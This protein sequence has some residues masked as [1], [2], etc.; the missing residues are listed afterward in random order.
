MEQA[1]QN[2]TEKGN[3]IASYNYTLKDKEQNEYIVD[4]IIYEK[5]FVIKAKQSSD[6]L[7]LI[8][9]NEICLNDLVQMHKKIFGYYENMQEIN[10]DYFKYLKKEDFIISKKD[11]SINIEIIIPHGFK[12]VNLFFDLNLVKNK[13]ED[14]SI[15]ISNNFNEFKKFVTDKINF[16][17]KA[18]SEKDIEIEKLNKKIETLIS[19]KKNKENLTNKKIDNCV[20]KFIYPKKII[21]CLKVDAQIDISNYIDYNLKFGLDWFKPGSSYELNDI[22]EHFK[23]VG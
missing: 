4:L 8:Y 23:L 16:L 14:N 6:I 7:N 22:I 12:K 15:N 20:K 17:E 11:N 3:K 19:D 5:K 2:T 21:Y 1:Q 9:K 13:I 18:N 10:E